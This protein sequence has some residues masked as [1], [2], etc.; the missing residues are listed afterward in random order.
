MV[1][2]HND[3]QISVLFKEIR[4]MLDMKQEAFAEFLDV[5]Q[6]CISKVERGV[7]EPKAS[8]LIKLSQRCKGNKAVQRKIVSIMMLTTEES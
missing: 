4:E 3:L 8:T 7:V 5:T 1:L 2:K 6:G